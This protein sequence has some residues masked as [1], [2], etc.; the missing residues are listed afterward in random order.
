MQVKNYDRDDYMKKNKVTKILAILIIL[1]LFLLLIDY[2]GFYELIKEPKIY[3]IIITYVILLLIIKIFD[4]GILKTMLFKFYNFID[5]FL[6]S[7][8]IASA[9][10]CILIKG[11]ILSFLNHKFHFECILIIFFTFLA[12]FIFRLLL[13]LVIKIIEKIKIKNESNVNDLYVLYNN[14]FK[15]EDVDNKII[16]L[17]EKEVDYDLLGRDDVKLELYNYIVNSKFNRK[18]TLGLIGKW[19]VGKSSILKKTLA[20]V[21]N[22]PEYIII[23]EFDPW[24]Y[25]NKEALLRGFFDV[26]MERSGVNFS[27]SKLELEYKKLKGKLLE[28][29][30]YISI[31]NYINDEKHLVNLDVNK[32]IEKYLKTEKK[33]IIF[34][35]DNI[36]RASSDNIRFLFNIINNV[37]NFPN[38]IYILLYD[39]V[40]VDGIMDKNSDKKFIDK[41]IDYELYVPELTAYHKNDILINVLKNVYSKYYEKDILEVIDRELMKELVDSMDDIRDMK[42]YLNYIIPRITIINN[43]L[44]VEDLIR[45]YILRKKN[46]E[47]YYDIKNNCSKYIKYGLDYSENYKY[48]YNFD[49]N[50]QQVREEYRKEKFENPDAKY[51]EHKELINKLFPMGHT[52]EEEQIRGIKEN[53]IFHGKNFDAYF[54]QFDR[55]F[56]E[57]NLKVRNFVSKVNFIDNQSEAAAIIENLFDDCKSQNVSTVIETILIYKDEINSKAISL[58]NKYLYDNLSS[59]NDKSVPLNFSPKQRAIIF[60][61]ETIVKMVDK[62]MN[63]FVCNLLSNYSEFD[64]FSS[65]IYWASSKEFRYNDD[66]KE[67]LNYIK[68]KF[69]EMIAYV[70]DNPRKINLY[71]DKYYSLKNIWG[72]YRFNNGLKEKLQNYIKKCIT[73]DNVTKLLGDFIRVGYTGTEYIYSFEKSTIECLIKEEDLDKILSKIKIE[74]LNEEQKFVL[75]VYQK[76]KNHNLK[77]DDFEVSFSEEKELNNL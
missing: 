67:K 53:R 25:E 71:S 3:K 5:D 22:N 35:I 16:I 55:G 28:G 6:V 13:L 60:I 72:I 48:E 54:T 19:G 75:S 21:E 65:I 15:K 9:L 39:K 18:L 32:I 51:H 56:I 10:N 17:E 8:T 77:N 40:I 69:K 29:L 52:S 12:I 42:K 2:F 7:G 57:I 4:I 11:D 68:S 62:E 33:K 24:I 59:L 46:S 27:S 23:R 44:N 63:C 50:E 37:F 74:Q 38:V 43:G 41:V 26:F 36:D 49:K 14:D 45:L 34:V 73:K 47:L 66:Q 31:L 61:G 30:Q 20:E 76:Y 70:L 64:T 1:S 58:V